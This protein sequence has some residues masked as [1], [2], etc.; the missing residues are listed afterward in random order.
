MPE[1]EQTRG[2]WSSIT[3]SL[4]A[5]LTILLLVT[6]VA[7]FAL[8]GYLNIRLHRQHLEAATLTSAERVSGIIKRSTSEY[9]LRNDREG[10]HHAIQA[11]ADEPGVAKVRIFDQQGLITYSTVAAEISHSVDKNG[12]ACYGCHAQSQPLT[13]LDRPDRFRIYANGHGRILGI[14]TPIEN[15][16]ACSNADCHAHP[17]SQQ[18]LGVLDANLSLATADAQIQQSTIRLSLYT[19]AAMLIVAFLSWLSIRK[20]VA[21]PFRA[22]T[23]STEHLSH[24]DLGYQIDVQSNDELGDLARSFNVMSLQLRAANEQIVAWA[25]TLEDRVDEK[26]TELRRAHGHMLQVEKMASIGKLAAVVAHEI[27]NPLSGILT[28][29]KLLEKWLKRHELETKEQ[30]AVAALQLIACESRRCGEIVKNLLIFSR[31]APMNVESTSLNVIIDRSI[32]LVQHQLDMAG[33]EVQ[34]GLA[35]DLPQ[36]QCDPGQIEQVILA[37]IVNAIDAMPHGG[38]LWVQSRMGPGNDEASFEIRDDGV[39]IPPDI[40]N[41]IFEPFVTTKDVGHGVGLGLAVSRSIIERHGGRIHVQSQVGE[42]T[43]FVVSLPLESPALAGAST[44]GAGRSNA[45]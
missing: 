10:L 11:I 24:G 5:R 30:D 28:Y 14:I 18:I 13:R 39:G 34:L 2:P 22:L 45:R 40:L 7:I 21:E 42:G 43:T 9:M 32:R 4:S 8:L 1:I 41:N 3:H 36:A 37:L 20:L 19:V 27:N 16:P 38:I 35:Q 26:T 15:Q 44:A 17:A 25:K 6:M 29:A 23:R 33:I 12:E 31:T